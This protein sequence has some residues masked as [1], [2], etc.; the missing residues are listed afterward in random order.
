MKIQF[1][2]D[3]GGFKFEKLRQK[4]NESDRKNPV[5]KMRYF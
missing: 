3:Y 5:W 4:L 1:V 2:I